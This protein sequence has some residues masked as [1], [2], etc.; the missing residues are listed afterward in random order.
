MDWFGLE[1]ASVRCCKEEKTMT[2]FE[3]DY[4]GDFGEFWQKEARNKVEK[5]KEDFFYGARRTDPV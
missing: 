4:R 1:I 3:M 2:R 5:M